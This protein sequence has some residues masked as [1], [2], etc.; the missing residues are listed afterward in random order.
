MTY[1]IQYDLVRF[2][3]EPCNLTLKL[4]QNFVFF[5]FLGTKILKPTLSGCLLLSAEK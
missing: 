2:T 3:L 4:F 1:V 5:L